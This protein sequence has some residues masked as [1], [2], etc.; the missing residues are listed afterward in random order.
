[1]GGRYSGEAV[2]PKD[3]DPVEQLSEVGVCHPAPPG[4]AGG[5]AEAA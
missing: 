4:R 3:G 5:P 1:M 2:F